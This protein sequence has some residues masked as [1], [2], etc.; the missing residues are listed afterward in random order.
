MFILEPFVEEKSAAA[1]RHRRALHQIPETGFEEYK[2]Q[3]Y[4][5]RALESLSGVETEA[6]AGTGLVA[7]IRGESE[8]SVGFRADMDAL[9]VTEKTGLSFASQHPGKMHAC[10]H[11]G[12]MTMGLLL[13]QVLSEQRH[14]LKKSVLLIFQPAEE[15]PGGAKV[16]V[17]AGILEKY[18]VEAVFGYH[19]FPEVASGLFA[20]KSG[21]LM[22]MTGEFDIELTGKS[23]HGALPH[24][25]VDALL[26]ASGLVSVLQSVVS[27]NVK[28]TESAV[29]TVGKMISGEKRNV[30]AG[31]ARLEGTFRAFSKEVFDASVK[32]MQEIV[33]SV[34]TGYGCEASIE[35]RSMYPPVLN[36]PGLTE[37]FVD[38]VGR[39]NVLEIEPQMLA[40]DFS[41]YQEAVPGL[42]VFVGCRDAVHGY[43]F[44]L[45]HEKFNF[46]ERV[47]LNGVSAMIKVFEKAGVLV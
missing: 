32:R 37:L 28:P 47:L 14:R 7:W 4:L 36:D 3:R 38:A 27:R 11:D 41:Y 18:R 13:A 21:P 16:L 46:D 44:G 45:H 33:T 29:L 39:E 2:T 17:E 40:E 43:H 25:G 24:L 34:A 30:I 8:A 23:A 35:V 20:T 19:L 26:A 10:G 1:V 6:V 42:F 5:Q 22:A 9:E 12:H 15:G 31:S